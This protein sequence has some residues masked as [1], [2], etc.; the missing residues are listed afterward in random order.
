MFLSS[1]GLKLLVAFQSDAWNEAW[2]TISVT[3]AIPFQMHLLP[4]K[5]EYGYSNMRRVIL[6]WYEKDQIS[7]RKNHRKTSYMVK[8]CNSEINLQ[9]VDHEPCGIYS[10][11]Q[12]L[13]FRTNSASLVSTECIKN[14]Y[15]KVSGRMRIKYGCRY[16]N[17]K[18]TNKGY[19]CTGNESRQLKLW[20][21]A[22][23]AI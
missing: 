13:T 20:S 1:R 5:K 4:Y 19:E 22:V 6:Y 12:V 23:Q 10:Y 8:L 11:F 3:F 16:V 9:W 15:Q 21:A 2:K 7:F 18:H 14:H 17:K